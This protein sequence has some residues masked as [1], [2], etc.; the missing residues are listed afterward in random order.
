[1]ISRR[2]GIRES[3]VKKSEVEFELQR[4]K[5]HKPPTPR[6]GLRPRYTVSAEVLEANRQN[7]ERARARQPGP[8]AAR[9]ALRLVPFAGG[10]AGPGERVATLCGAG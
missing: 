4:W 1:M 5:N 7:L 6:T 9:L 2:G 8:P 10:L 3:G